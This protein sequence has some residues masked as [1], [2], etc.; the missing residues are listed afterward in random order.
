MALIKVDAEPAEVGFDASRLAR[1]DRHFRRYVDDGL[2]AG[3]TV[4]VSRRG[5]VAYLSH[6]GM[7]DLDAGL[8]VTDDTIW[9]IYSMVRRRSTVRFRKGARASRAVFTWTGVV[10]A[11]RCS[12]VGRAS[13]S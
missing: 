7:R 10:L 11:K 9:R 1:I 13:G 2:L 12:S 5:R 4:A 3:L 6:Q 8:P